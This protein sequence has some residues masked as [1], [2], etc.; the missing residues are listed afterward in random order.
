MMFLW[1][2]FWFQILNTKIFHVYLL[3]YLLLTYDIR[4]TFKIMFVRR[5]RI[6]I[7][8]AFLYQKLWQIYLTLLLQH[9]YICTSHSNTKLHLKSLDSPSLIFF[10]LFR[11]IQKH[12]NSEKLVNELISTA[13]SLALARVLLIPRFE[14]K[15]RHERTGTTILTYIFRRL[16]NRMT[17][18]IKRRQQI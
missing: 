6:I 5:K 14:T 4:I 15:I 11:N 16:N 12:E 18:E 1:F 8:A 3:F 7:D 10:T 9:Q 13:L 17:G 2:P